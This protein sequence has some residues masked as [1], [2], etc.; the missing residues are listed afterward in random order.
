MARK[1]TAKQAIQPLKGTGGEIAIEMPM[2]ASIMP[3]MM[4]V[5]LS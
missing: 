4:W 3:L 1:K 2:I 5:L